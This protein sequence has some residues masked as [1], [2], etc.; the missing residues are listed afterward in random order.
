MRFMVVMSFSKG[1]HDVLTKRIISLLVI[2]ARDP[3]Q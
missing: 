3:E 1:N 2:G